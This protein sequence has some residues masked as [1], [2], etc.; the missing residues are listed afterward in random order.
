MPQSTAIVWPMIAHVLLVMVLYGLLSLRRRTAV[1]GGKARVSQ[2][3]E[4]LVEPDDSLFVRNSISNQFELPVL[5]HVVCLALL[6]TGHATLY[7]VLVA[8][9][10]VLS[11]YVHAYVHVTSNRIR[12]RRPLFM[13]GFLLHFLLWLWLAINLA[14]N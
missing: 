1:A 7:P 6:A 11:R 12:H 5:F 13:I 9:A 10:F 14:T 2:F 4:N 3:R 8:W